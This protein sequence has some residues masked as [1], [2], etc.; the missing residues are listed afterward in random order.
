MHCGFLK[1][2]GFNKMHNRPPIFFLLILG[3]VALL[4][5]I[6]STPASDA[7]LLLQYR[8][9]G[10]LALLGDLYNRYMDLVYGVCLKYL[11]EPEDAQDA[12]MAIFEELVSKL[13][14][15]Q[16]ENFRSWLYTLA[17]NHCLMKLRQQKKLP[18]GKIPEEF[19]QSDENGHLQNVLAREENFRQLEECLEQLTDK[20]RQV[21]E[22][23]YLKEKCYNEI[24]AE[25]GIEWNSVRSYIQNGRRNLKNCMEA[26]QKK[27]LSNE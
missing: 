14:Q 15:H 6:S 27:T 4:R 11:K 17:K 20:Q 2:A 9:A 26:Q 7:E 13:K 23:F 24:S 10:D 3:L 5:N 21:I 12:V 1:D 18:V 25:T 8:N 19:M 22:L 16:V